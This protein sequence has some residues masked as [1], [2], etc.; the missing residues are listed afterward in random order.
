MDLSAYA[1]EGAITVDVM[2]AI[3]ERRSIRKY[4]PEPVTEEALHTILE[5]ARWAPSWSNSQCWMLIIVRDQK[6]KSK[7]VD[8]LKTSIAVGTK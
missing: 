6:T 7:Q 5:A 3:K 2:Q 4:R 8:T 1:K